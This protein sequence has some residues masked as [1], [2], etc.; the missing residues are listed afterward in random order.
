[1]AFG[2]GRNNQ[3]ASEGSR[4]DTPRFLPNLI[5]CLSPVI[6]GIQSARQP[7][8]FTI[9][10]PWAATVAGQRGADI[11]CHGPSLQFLWPKILRTS[12][13][14]VIFFYPVAWS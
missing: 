6:L 13:I 1:M 14:L 12:N 5:P 8:G 9:A 2:L 7:L 3:A 11:S 10:L 4:S